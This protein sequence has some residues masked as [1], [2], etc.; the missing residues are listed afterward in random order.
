MARRMLEEVPCAICGGNDADALWAIDSFGYGES[1]L[2][3][4]KCCG[5]L[6]YSPRLNERALEEVY[7]GTSDS[8]NYA[9]F[10]AERAYATKRANRCIEL[11]QRFSGTS[12]P[13]RLLDV[14][15]GF[16]FYLQVARR[17]GWDAVGVEPAKPVAEFASEQLGLQVIASDFEHAELEPPFDVIMFHHVLEHLRHPKQALCK[18]NHLLR[19]GGLLLLS[20]PNAASLPARLAGQE[21]VWFGELHLYHFTPITICRLLELCGFKP[22]HTETHHGHMLSDA[23]RVAAN[24][25]RK[26]GLKSGAMHVRGKREL[27][28][29]TAALKWAFRFASL[30]VWMP[31]LPFIWLCYRLGFGPDLWV[32]SRKQFSVGCEA[33]SDLGD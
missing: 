21:W 24:A 11:I 29:A 17:H 22:I 20:V 25:L 30:M 13:G 19:Y 23:S 6:Y 12:T 3:R 31:L 18:A 2:R 15:C 4:C 14:G 7:S 1:V 27:S 32:L 10:L 9:D 26:V 5:L 33:L 16:G 8:Y 28:E